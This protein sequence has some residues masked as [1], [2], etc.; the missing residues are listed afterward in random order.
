[1]ELIEIP[2]YLTDYEGH[3][4][5]KISRDDFNFS[6]WNSISSDCRYGSLSTTEI[7]REYLYF[8]TTE[9]IHPLLIE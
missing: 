1:M 4:M 2:F 8:V 6:I 7:N 9:G 5:E 3:T